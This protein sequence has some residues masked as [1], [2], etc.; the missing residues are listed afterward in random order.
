MQGALEEWA[1]EMS[2]IGSPASTGSFPCNVTEAP[3]GVYFQSAGPLQIA[4]TSVTFSPNRSN[5]QQPWPTGPAQGTFAWSGAGF[6][7]NLPAGFGSYQA[8]FAPGTQAG[9]AALVSERN[10]QWYG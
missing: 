2:L 10:T 3:P 8:D 7:L 6:T 1:C 4:G 9:F 5:G